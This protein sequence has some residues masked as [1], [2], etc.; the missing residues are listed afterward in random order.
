MKKYIF[1]ISSFFFI[2]S[3]SKREDSFK[4]TYGMID[5]FSPVGTHTGY[6]YPFLLNVNDS[7]VITYGTMPFWGT[8]HKYDKIGDTLKFSSKFYRDRQDN[9]IYICETII[10]GKKKLYYFRKFDGL[11]TIIDKDKMEINSEKLASFLNKE[12]FEGKYSYNKKVV[13]FFGD[14]S[15][16]GLNEFYY[17]IARPRLG[18]LTFYDDCIIETDKKDIWRYQIRNDELILTKYT[19]KRDSDEHFILSDEQIRLKKIKP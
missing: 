17:F 5:Y 11:D 9:E 7:T 14:G 18:T 10:D 16:K 2:C 6:A 12:L 8:R 4:G 15:V 13:E 1:L 19:D 3:C